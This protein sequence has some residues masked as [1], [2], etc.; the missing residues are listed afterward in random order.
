[1]QAALGAKRGL[2]LTARKQGPQSY[3]GKEW[4]SANYLN[5]LANRFFPRGPT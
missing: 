2:Y 1:M 5:E 4:N 3:N